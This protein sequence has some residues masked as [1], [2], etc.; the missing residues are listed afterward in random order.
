MEKELL[1]K[2]LKIIS[3]EIR[4][5]RKKINQLRTDA[6]NLEFKLNQFTVYFFKGLSEMTIPQRTMEMM[7]YRYG[8]EGKRHTLEETGN[9]F[10]V[11]GNRARQLLE[12]GWIIF[13][14]ILEFG[15]IEK[16]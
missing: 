1:E 6:N 14:R 9:H 2:Q 12:K 8:V 15:K 4:K 13:E 5:E 11:C 7:K 3:K 10:N 16:D